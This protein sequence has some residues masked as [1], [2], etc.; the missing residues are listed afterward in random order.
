[1]SETQQFQTTWASADAELLAI[2]LAALPPIVAVGPVKEFE[3][4][5][6]TSYAARLSTTE[7]PMG[8]PP[9]GIYQSL[10]PVAGVFMEGPPP[11][12]L[13]QLL[14][15]LRDLGFINHAEALAAAKTGDIP[16]SLQGALWAA[17]PDEA[18]RRDIEL[19]WAAMYQAN[20][21]SPF[22]AF[23]I[24]AGIATAE[25]IDAVFA[26]ARTL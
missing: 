12:S 21:T 3:W 26:L 25:Q 2:A 1:M 19:L 5:G 24:A 18:T 14:F 11:V 22:W 13:S 4:L 10:A 16:A 23:V 17:V 9:A 8:A 20:R 6:V 7:A 15:A